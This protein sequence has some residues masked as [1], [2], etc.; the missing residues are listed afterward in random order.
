[1]EYDDTNLSLKLNQT[2]IP[3]N[4]YIWK[5]G[6]MNKYESRRI[7]NNCGDLVDCMIYI[8]DATGSGNE[9]KDWWCL[10]C[11]YKESKARFDADVK[12]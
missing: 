1:M 9:L 11:L 7:C 8:M 3:L 10:K 2:I 5:V 4:L 6:L 12:N